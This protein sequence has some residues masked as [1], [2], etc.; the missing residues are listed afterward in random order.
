L[1][2]ILTAHFLKEAGIDC[3]IAEG[4]RILSGVTANTTAQI[5]A[6]NELQYSKMAKSGAFKAKSFLHANLWAVEKYKE[7]Q[8]ISSA[9]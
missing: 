3:M 7:M 8:R 9:I 5:T 2:G 4:G 6:Q 1:A